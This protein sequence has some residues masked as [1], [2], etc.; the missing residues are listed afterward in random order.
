[1]QTVTIGN[2]LGRV[3]PKIIYLDTNLWNRLL[4][5]NVEPATLLSRLERCGCTLALSGQNVYELTR[6]FATSTDR[7]KD[8]FRYIKVYVDAGIAGAYDGMDLLRNEVKTLYAHSDSV[9]A[10]YSPADYDALKE[11]IAKLAEGIVEERAE[12]FLSE[13]G[14]F[15]RTSREGQKAHLES[16][17]DMK[18]GL[19]AVTAES[20]TEWLDEQVAADIGAA[21]L[22]AHLLR[23]YESQDAY[24]AIST[25]LGLLQHPASRMAKAV[26]RAD[27]YSNWRCAHRGSNP[28]DL[29]DDMYHVLNAAY[30]DFYATAESGQKEYAS[31]LLCQWTRAAFYDEKTPL[32]D[33]LSTLLEGECA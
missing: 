22:S 1:V 27:L 30:C 25:A 26:V 21:L 5:Q 18:A 33:W 32:G 16:R 17:P 23:I 15:A 14:K 31:L 10:F 7:G 2:E 28:R 4:D 6:T 29:I 11:E 12:T 3:P 24:A 8:L 9:V 19:L 13:R 20:L